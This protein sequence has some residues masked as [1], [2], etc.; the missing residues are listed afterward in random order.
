MAISAP[1]PPADFNDTAAGQ[2]KKDKGQVELPLVS[3]W[4]KFTLAGS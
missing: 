3:N 1:S 4:P 2:D